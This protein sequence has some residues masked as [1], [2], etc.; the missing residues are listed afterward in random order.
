MC[1]VAS[2]AQYEDLIE[3]FLRVFNS[4][5]VISRFLKAV[6]EMEVSFTGEPLRRDELDGPTL[7]LRLPQT[8]SPPSSEAIAL[9]RASSPSML[10]RGAITTYGTL[11]E[12]CSS[13]SAASRRS[14]AW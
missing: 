2:A 12:I 3:V 1:H 6:I 11:F 10:A 7:T 13:R 8:T 14:S 5:K 4:R 9:R